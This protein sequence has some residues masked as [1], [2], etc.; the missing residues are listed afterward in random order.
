MGGR[1]VAKIYLRLGQI[2]TAY[3]RRH[4][5]TVWTLNGPLK[6]LSGET[7]YPARIWPFFSSFPNLPPFSLFHQTPR[8]TGGR[9]GICVTFGLTFRVPPSYRHGLILPPR[10]VSLLVVKSLSNK[11]SFR[12]FM[13]KNLKMNITGHLSRS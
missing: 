7:H 9:M 1:G 6:W 11:H 13:T 3:I 12:D 8:A 10:S 5:T 2:S 4:L